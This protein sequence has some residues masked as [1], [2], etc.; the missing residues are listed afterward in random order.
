M[1]KGLDNTTLYVKINLQQIYKSIKGSKRT[2]LRRT[3]QYASD[4]NEKKD[5]L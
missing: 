4:W 2:K 3:M 5:Y 1:K